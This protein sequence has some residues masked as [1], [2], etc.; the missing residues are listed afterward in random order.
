MFPFCYYFVYL[1]LKKVATI[2]PTK[3]NPTTT[4]LTIEINVPFPGL[5][6]NNTNINNAKT[7]NIIKNKSSA[8][9][10]ST[11]NLKH[12]NTTI[13]AIAKT[14]ITPNVINQPNE[15]ESNPEIES[16]LSIAIKT[17]KVNDTITIGVKIPYVEKIL[18]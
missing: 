18:P 11:F 3:A 5:K 12:N 9:T 6:Q 8:F 17:T 4:H 13:P 10:S 7:L 14:P 1:D 15:E 2:L 16:F